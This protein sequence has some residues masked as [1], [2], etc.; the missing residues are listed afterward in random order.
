VRRSV[1][2]SPA[3]GGAQLLGQFVGQVRPA[4]LAFFVAH[5]RAGRAQGACEL[6]QVAGP[7]VA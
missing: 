6:A 2:A 4:D 7:A 5:Q 3:A 1:A